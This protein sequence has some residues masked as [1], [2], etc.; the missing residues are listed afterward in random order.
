MNEVA[1][2]VQTNMFGI[3]DQNISKVFKGSPIKA[4]DGTD[5]GMSMTLRSR[6]EIAAEFDLKGRDNKD[7][8]D[9]AILSQS[10]AAFRLAKG[11]IA[12]LGAEW[13]LAKLSTRTLASGVRQITLVSKE[14]RRNNGPSDEKI[15]EAL[16]LTVQ[17]VS[18]LRQ[19]QLAKLK[20]STVEV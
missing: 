3:L 17:E 6:K 12:G 2:T 4:K 14:V 19:Q 10:D 16:G 8:L 7:E 5:A 11:H 1:T 9:A 18:E 13:T 20:Q 15:A